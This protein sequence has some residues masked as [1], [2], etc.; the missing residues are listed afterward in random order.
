MALGARGVYFTDGKHNEW[1]PSFQVKAVDTTAA[2]DVFTGAFAVALAEHQSPLEACGFACAAAAISVT[3]HGAQP[4]APIGRKS[5]HCSTHKRIFLMAKV[6]EIGVTVDELAA[7]RNRID[8]TKRFEL[9]DRVPVIPAIAHRFLVPITGTRFREYY[10]D[11]ETM[12]RTQLLAQK[13]LMENIRTD[14]F[15]ITGPWVGAWT[16]FKNSLKRGASVVR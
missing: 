6:I 5:M 7:R 8:Q 14:A 2:G 1:I 9:P 16:D 13:W 11:A 3:R 4:S 12:L 10:A 15:S